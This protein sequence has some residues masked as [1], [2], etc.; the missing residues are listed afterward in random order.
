MCS[1]HKA[2]LVRIG[3]ELC[4]TSLRVVRRL[5]IAGE[6]RKVSTVINLCMY[7][8][9]YTYI[10]SFSESSYYVTK[11]LSTLHSAQYSWTENYH[12]NTE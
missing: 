7:I 11:I 6:H 4:S 9:M 12:I 3:G 8:Y 1:S 2:L 10:H 5:L